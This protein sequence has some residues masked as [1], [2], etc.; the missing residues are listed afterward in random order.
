MGELR[1]PHKILFGKPRE[2]RRQG[3]EASIKLK[4]IMKV[5]V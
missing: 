5:V 4:G 1:H 3:A 2:L